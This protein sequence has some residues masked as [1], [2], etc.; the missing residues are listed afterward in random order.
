MYPVPSYA[1][2]IWVVGNE[3]HLALP[4]LEG[5]KQGHTVVLPWNAKA[6]DHLLRI[7]RQRATQV[8]P[9]NIA[10]PAGPTQ[11]DIEQLMKAVKKAPKKLEETTVNE[12]AEL[13]FTDAEI[14]AELKRR[15]G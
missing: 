9:L 15:F 14:E 12:V 5:N 1:A 6:L 2:N 4:P 7:L 3:I 13:D 10:T 8:R 11:W